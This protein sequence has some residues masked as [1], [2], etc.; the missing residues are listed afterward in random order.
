MF[1]DW[2]YKLFAALLV[3]LMFVS[4]SF[5]GSGISK[6]KNKREHRESLE[7]LKL[8]LEINRLKKKIYSAYDIKEAS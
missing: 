8:E 5:L 7:I 3:L 4:A 1:K 6:G 2:P